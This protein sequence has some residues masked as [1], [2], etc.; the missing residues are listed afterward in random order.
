MYPCP[1]ARGGGP[2]S[3]VSVPCWW[4]LSPC[5]GVARTSAER[6]GEP[7]KRPRV[8]WPCMESG[9]ARRSPI[10]GGPLSKMA[11]SAT[12]P[13]GRGGAPSFVITPRLCWRGSLP[14]RGWA[15]FG[16]DFAGRVPWTGGGPMSPHAFQSP[17]RWG[18]AA[19]GQDEPVDGGGPHGRGGEPNVHLSKVVAVV[20]RIGGWALGRRVYDDRRGSLQGWAV[21]VHCAGGC[22]QGGGWIS[23]RHESAWWASSAGG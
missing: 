16:D 17:R 20:P 9:G 11:S 14:R 5:L 6:S 18:C 7:G 8:G 12:G 23:E 2:S 10:G 21:C 19:R 3:Y 13:H 1:H 4:H 15:F 22:P